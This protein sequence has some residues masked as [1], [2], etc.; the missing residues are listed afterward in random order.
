MHRAL[1]CFLA[2]IALFFTAC[3]KDSPLS[4]SKGVT[5]QLRYW[6][7]N[8]ARGDIGYYLDVDSTHEMLSLKNL[9]TE[10]RRTDVNER[11]TVKF[12]DTHQTVTMDMLSSMS[13]PRIVVVLSISKL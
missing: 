7:G 10:F 4:D 2:A 13:G 1:F 3:S 5:G 12:F 6:V 9:P 8:P 11:V